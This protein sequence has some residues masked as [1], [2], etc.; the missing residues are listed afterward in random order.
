MKQRTRR[1]VL[2]T[3]PRTNL[4]VPAPLLDAIKAHAKRNARKP[5]EE[6]IARLAATLENETLMS[7]DRLMRLIYCKE[8][9]YPIDV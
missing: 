5:S 9:A 7:H 4:Q 8:L 3:D 6:I 2:K 1:I